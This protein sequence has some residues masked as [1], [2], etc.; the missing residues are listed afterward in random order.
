MQIPNLVSAI[1][2]FCINLVFSLTNFFSFLD[3]GRIKKYFFLFFFVNINKKM[4]LS[5]WQKMIKKHTKEGKTMKQIAAMYKK[6]SGKKSRKA[7]RKSGRKVSRK[8]A[9]KVGGRRVSRKSAR[10]SARKTV[11]KTRKV[12]R[13]ASRKSGRKVSRKSARKASRKSGRK[14]RKVSMKMHDLEM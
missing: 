5:E 11:R 14:A 9:R 6:K 1:S 10:K 2:D 12:S 8:S 4:A 7:S 3:F 13:K